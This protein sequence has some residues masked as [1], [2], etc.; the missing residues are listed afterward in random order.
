MRRHHKRW[1]LLTLAALCQACGNNSAKAPNPTGYDWPERSV[2][3]V[4]YAAQS[5]RDTQVMVGYDETKKLRFAV[6]D[7][8]FLVWHDSVSK[9]SRVGGAPPKNQA[10]W[11]EDT[12]HYYVR[13][14][15]LGEI[16]GSE[17]GCD[18]ALPACRE[19]LPSALPLELRHIIPRLPVWWPPKGYEWEDTLTFDDL[20]RSRGARGSVVTRYRA[21]RDTVF[22][23][24]G[25]WIVTW[26]SLRRAFRNGPTGA[27]TA[28]PQI[29][30]RGAVFVDKQLLL[31]AYALWY[32]ALEAPPALQA[33]GIK[34]T[35]FRGRAFLMGS[36]F[37]SAEAS[38][39]AR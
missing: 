37:D 10:L 18:P 12:L 4:E 34:G 9:V 28:E 2:Y 31:P 16:S 15:R 11:P 17:P 38:G 29:E 3:R 13:L 8:G 14:G 27:M 5:Q 35:D 19:A 36:M 33:L 1:R 25:Y 21:A 23:G 39:R 7:D 6:R 22:R 32:G 26:H 30:E 20:P 24:R